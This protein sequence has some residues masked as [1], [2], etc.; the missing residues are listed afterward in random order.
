MHACIRIVI[1]QL[2]KKQDIMNQLD[3][4]NTEQPMSILHVF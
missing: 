4:K 2:E 1:N 3:K